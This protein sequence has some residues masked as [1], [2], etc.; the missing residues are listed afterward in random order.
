MNRDTSSPVVRTLS[1]DFS[2]EKALESEHDMLRKFELWDKDASFGGFLVSN[3]EQM[4]TEVACLLRQ[5]N[6]P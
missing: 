5:R 3:M 2:L 4:A 6:P 1:G